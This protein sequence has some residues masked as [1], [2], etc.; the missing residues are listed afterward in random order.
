MFD[1]GC[2]VWPQ[3]RS[4]WPESS[5]TLPWAG[6][7]PHVTLDSTGQWPHITL[8]RTVATHYLGQYSCHTLP[9]TVQRP[10]SHWKSLLAT[11]W[12][13]R[14]GYVLSRSS[15]MVHVSIDKET[16][17]SDFVCLRTPAVVGASM[18]TKTVK[19]VFVCVNNLFGN[20]SAQHNSSTCF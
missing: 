5:H 7:S 12:N 6:Q 8:G 13:W 1:G 3:R 16:V 15:S 18:A 2:L 20:V 17:F 14:H 10:G 11:R 9:W 19:T 4:P